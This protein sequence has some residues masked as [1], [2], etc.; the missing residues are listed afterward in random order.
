MLSNSTCGYL[1]GKHHKDVTNPSGHSAR[2]HH[3]LKTHSDTWRLSPKARL[4]IGRILLNTGGL[5]GVVPPLLGWCYREKCIPGGGHCVERGGWAGRGGLFDSKRK[6]NENAFVFTT[7]M[8]KT[9]YIHICATKK[10]KNILLHHSVLQL[11]P[12]CPCSLHAWLL[13]GTSSD[14]L[15]ATPHTLRTETCGKLPRQKQG[16]PQESRS[17]G[18]HHGCCKSARTEALALLQ[19]GQ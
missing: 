18:R 2:H 10:E 15:T 16:C 14:L 13:T 7:A 11:S 8:S 5:G 3:Y 9:A 4:S 12:P 1:D 19:P 6:T 17:W